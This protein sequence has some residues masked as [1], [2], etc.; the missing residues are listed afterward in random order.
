VTQPRSRRRGLALVLGVVL[1]VVLAAGAA[2]GGYLITHNIR[3]HRAASTTTP[4]APTPSALAA[5]TDAPSSSPS[6]AS[7]PAPRPAAV[8]ATVAPAVGDPALGGRLLA[9][10]VDATT[11]TVLYD[12]LGSSPAA[13]ASTAKLL[14]AAAVLA[15]R[16]PT[17]RITTRVL[18]GA[19]GTIVLVGGG[20]PTL[21]GAAAGQAGAYADAAR[22]SDLATQVHRSHATVRRIVVDNSAFT[23][24]S[25]S[26]DWAGEDVPSDYA[27]AITAVMTD[28]GRAAPDDAIRSAAP[29]LAA[30]HELAAALRVP[31]VAVTRGTAPARAAVLATV[32][33][34]PMS[35]LINQ[36]LQESDNVIAEC[37][38]RQVA[39]ATHRPASFAGAAAATRAVLA[40][41]GADPGPGLRD[42]SGLAANDRI[43]PIA[44]ARVLRVIVSSAHPALHN[45]VAALPV[46]AWSGTLVDR[47]LPGSSA[48]RGAGVVRAKTGTLTAVSTLAGMVHDTSGRL[49]VFALL[50]DRVP[51]GV[52]ATRAAEAALD[53]VA[54]ALAGC[55]CR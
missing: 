6:T 42:G 43:S 39:I 12:H 24:P 48:G 21:S 50:A 51:A 28:G 22:I 46:A 11:G 2:V 34:A 17:D 5:A 13:P 40:G 27:A 49:L 3:I 31:G 20:D 15:V 30:G 38:A 4:P 23:G 18:A 7:G 54:A 55:G 53:R 35:V 14:T 37:L 8:A 44:L 33:S 1:V 10:V 32:K 29:D 47:Y 25:V 16:A 52:P 41:V 9:E 19:P 26:G 45:I 36:M